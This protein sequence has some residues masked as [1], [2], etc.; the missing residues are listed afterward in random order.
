MHVVRITAGGIAC[1]LA[2]AATGCGSAGQAGDAVASAAAER[3]E[4][5]A[6]TGSV[7]NDPDDPA[8]WIHPTAPAESVIL[9]TD[10]IEKT[11][12]LYVFG[13]DGAVRQSIEG[14]DRPNNVDVEYGFRMPAGTTDI[15]VLTERKQHRLRIFSIDAKGRLSDLAPEGLPVLTGEQ[16]DAAEPMGIA[17]YKRP[18]DG[19]I[20]AIVAP[21]TGGTENYL[22]QYR[23]DVDG[24]GRP[25]STLVRRFGRFS[26]AGATPA[27][28]GE[29]EAIVVDDAMGFVYYR[30]ER[31]GIRKYHADP[32]HP[33]AARELAVFGT[34]G[35]LGDR[36]G[37]AIYSTGER[38]GFIV[39]SDQIP[40]GSRTKLYPREGTPG[41]P[42]DH[43]EVRTV[44]T[45]SDG[46]DGLET[47]SR[48]LPGFPR[49]LL[50]MMNADGRNF[51]LYDWRAVAADR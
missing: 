15:A 43:P 32:N 7:P 1:V 11:G 23:L 18:A 34:S 8:I 3:L 39:A 37:L 42:H 29:I 51:L 19:A 13:L 33:E 45:V 25:R 2:L 30:D 4:P 50:A 16:G 14:I 6:R 31:Y 10:K 5:A 12:G 27:E 21:K 22:W 44:P 41:N 28:I 24:T 47:T 9:G 36:E 20:F 35:F 38:T 49:G 46:T 17:L 26:R 40:N 48:A